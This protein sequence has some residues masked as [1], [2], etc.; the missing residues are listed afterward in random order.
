MG[1]MT[2]Q[3]LFLV[4]IATVGCGSALGRAVHDKK[5]S[6][7]AIGRLDEPPLNLSS[8]C[9]PNELLSFVETMLLSESL[10]KQLASPANCSLF[11]GSSDLLRTTKTWLSGFSFGNLF[12]VVDVWKDRWEKRRERR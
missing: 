3:I 4:S 9:F 7:A 10:P 12:L 2:R 6:A 11:G 1:R 5:V 8:D